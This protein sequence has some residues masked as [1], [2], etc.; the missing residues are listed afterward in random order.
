MNSHLQEQCFT[1]HY[2]MTFISNCEEIIAVV[3]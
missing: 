3:K 2:W 1:L